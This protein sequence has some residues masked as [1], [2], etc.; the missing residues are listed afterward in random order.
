MGCICK[1]GK[2]GRNHLDRYFGNA[3]RGK[4]ARL[5]KRCK[6]RLRVDHDNDHD[7]LDDLDN[8]HDKHDIDD[9]HVDNH[10]A[11][12]F[13]MRRRFICGRL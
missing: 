10:N 9:D 8:K 11:A 6:R 7:N 12:K 3:L 2:F 4:L 13:I 5:Y 1:R